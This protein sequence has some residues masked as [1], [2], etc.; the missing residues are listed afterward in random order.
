MRRQGLLGNLT[1]SL[2]IFAAAMLASAP[3]QAPAEAPAGQWN[4]SRG[5]VYCTLGRGNGPG[6]VDFALRVIPGTERVDLLVTSRGWQRIPIP[7][8][9]KA[10]I[11]LLPEDGA[12]IEAPA[13]TGRLPSGSPLLA[14]GALGSKFIDRLALAD[15]IRVTQDART[16]LTLDLTDSGSAVAALRDCLSQRLAAW[17]MDPGARARMRSLPE[18]I[19]TPFS[20]NDYPLGAMREDAQG[21]VIARLMIG[22][23]GRVADCAVLRT[24]GSADLDSRTCHVYR[25]EARFRPAIGEDGQPVAAGT[26]TSVVWGIGG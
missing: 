3:A 14:F 21:M 26:I 13:L 25:H 2:P 4:I 20:G 16:V 15:Q 11:A 1:R 10:G 22:T 19:G 23:D 8:G 12:P 9:E 17:G 18:P 24:S 6:G 7:R 5:E